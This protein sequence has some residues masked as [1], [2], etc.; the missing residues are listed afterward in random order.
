MTW[1]AM[2]YPGRGVGEGLPLINTDDTDQNPGDKKVNPG[3]ELYKRF[4]ILIE[5]QGGGVGQIAI[6]A[7]IG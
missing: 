5:V 2:G 1:D 4:R 6:I 7:K 3:D